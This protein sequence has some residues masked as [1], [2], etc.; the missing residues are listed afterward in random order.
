MDAKVGAQPYLPFEANVGGD[1]LVI[2]YHNGQYF[3]YFLY[4]GNRQH[5]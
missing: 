1:L 3:L 4:F 2:Y 5:T